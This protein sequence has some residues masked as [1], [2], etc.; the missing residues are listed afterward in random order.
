M[1][2]NS[3]RTDA[4]ATDT[5]HAGANQ[6]HHIVLLLPDNED[7]RILEKWLEPRFTVTATSDVDRLNDE[8]DLCLF[9]A[10][11]FARHTDTF[12]ERKERAA[13][14]FLPFLLILTDHS[15]SSVTPRVWKHVDELVSAPV[16]KSELQARITG[17]LVR[18]DLS[19]ALAR[20]EERIRQILQTIPDPILIVDEAGTIIDTNPAFDE[21][22]G[23]DEDTIIGSPLAAVEALPQETTDILT[24][25]ITEDHRES[26]TAQ[27]PGTP[28]ANAG[29]G[30]PDPMT[31]SYQGPDGETHYADV[32]TA[33]LTDLQEED[34]QTLFVLRDVTARLHREDELE[35]ERDRLKQFA[36][37]LAH[38]IRNPLNIA[39]GYLQQIT[40]TDE[41]TEAFEQVVTSHTRMAQMVKE[42]LAHARGGVTNEIQSVNLATI[43][44][45]AWEQTATKDAT[46]D[47]SIDELMLDADPENL[48]TILENLFRNALEHGTDTTVVRVGALDNGGFFIED[49][50]PGIPREDRE[51]VFERGFTTDSAG[52]GLGL[53]LVYQVAVAHNWSVQVTESDAGGAR[54][55][56]RVDPPTDGIPD[57]PNST[58]DVPL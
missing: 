22:T 16:D 23:S 46:L 54:F 39:E 7:R 17:L 31:I 21:F 49:D 37:M 34:A 11:T 2:R 29:N 5:R 19:R 57:P 56:F 36:A 26:G 38:E 58:D 42:L 50:G 47:I 13:P 12:I 6:S 52:T 44:R 48:Q 43:A 30:T 9:D 40:P 35:R 8:F 15:P 3:N 32:A 28:P 10:T 45:V 4:I 25:L 24:Q 55:E 14:T 18:R 27:R 33:P 51:R 41:E 53:A 1:T 20:R